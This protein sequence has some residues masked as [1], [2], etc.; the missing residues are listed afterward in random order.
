MNSGAATER[1]GTYKNESFSYTLKNEPLIDVPTGLKMGTEKPT[2]AAASLNV[3][4]VASNQP[5]SMP[6][7][8]LQE[9]FMKVPVWKK[10]DRAICNSIRGFLTNQYA[11][12]ADGTYRFVNVN[13]SSSTDT[14]SLRYETGTYAVND[15]QLTNASI[16]GA[17]EEWNKSGKISNGNSDVG[18]RKINDSWN[19]KVNTGSRKLE[20][21]TYT[22]SIGENGNRSGLVLQHNEC[23]ERE[24]E[25]SVSYLNEMTPERSLK[26]PDGF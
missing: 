4:Q 15:N 19:T 5:T 20:S 13:T 1:D 17:N 26:L 24:G 14:K 10:Q 6:Q 22:F 25:G 9:K 12:Y 16:K 21:C 3:Q 11:F 8:P 18:N 2:A 7:H 23:T